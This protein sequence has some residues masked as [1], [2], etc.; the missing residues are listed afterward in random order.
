MSTLCVK[1][2]QTSIQFATCLCQRIVLTS[3]YLVCNVL[4]YDSNGDSPSFF[5]QTKKKEK[6]KNRESAIALA[7]ETVC[8]VEHEGFRF[9][10]RSF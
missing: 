2:A 7:A 3:V 10:I 4:F 1:C 9:K 6:K 5:V 8:T